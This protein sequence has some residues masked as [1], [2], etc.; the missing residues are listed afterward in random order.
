MLLLLA[1]HVTCVYTGKVYVVTHGYIM[2]HSY[3]YT[4]AYIMYLTKRGQVC[5][6]L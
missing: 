4:M 2:Y 1:L 5:M 3:E 6:R